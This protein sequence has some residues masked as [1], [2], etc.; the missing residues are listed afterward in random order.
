[1]VGR[2]QFGQ[3]TPRL[4]TGRVPVSPCAACGLISDRRPRSSGPA[5]WGRRFGLR[6]LPAGTNQSGLIARVEPQTTPP[7]GPCN[8]VH[9]DATGRC[10][11][12]KARAARVR[13]HARPK[14]GSRKGCLNFLYPRIQCF[15][16]ANVAR[17]DMMI[18]QTARTNGL[19]QM[20]AGAACAVAACEV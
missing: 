11:P 6:P 2:W 5:S 7:I 8:H 1:M 19:G 12:V 20:P 13:R 9:R 17:S 15:I 10:G 14:N 3:K 18:R 16:R 4:S